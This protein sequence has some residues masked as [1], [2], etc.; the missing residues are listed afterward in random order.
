MRIL[1][2]SSVS[3]SSWAKPAP[4]FSDA[5]KA[6]VWKISASS[7]LIPIEENWRAYPRTS[8]IPIVEITFSMPLRSAEQRLAT[9]FS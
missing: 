8:W 5:A 6:S 2:R 9:S 1:W 3:P 7:G 4:P